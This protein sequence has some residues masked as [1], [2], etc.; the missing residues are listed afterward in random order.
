ML[1]SL[2]SKPRI[3]SVAVR[4]PLLRGHK[5]SYEVK[6][7]NK[8]ERVFNKWDDLI[9]FMC[10]PPERGPELFTL[11]FT[12]RGEWVTFSDTSTNEDEEALNT[13]ILYECTDCGIRPDFTITISHDQV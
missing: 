12:N 10:F 4:I 9:N 3:I 2:S 5:T 6:L 8:T 1:K 11:C 7:S 13:P